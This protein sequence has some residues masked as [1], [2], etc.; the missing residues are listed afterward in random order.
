[1]G[2]IK[3]FMT[4]LLTIIMLL[5]LLLTIRHAGEKMRAG[6]DINSWCKTTP[7]HVHCMHMLGRNKPHVQHNRTQFRIMALEAAVDLAQHTQG[8]AS[9]LEKLC[10]SKRKKAVWKDCYKL[11]NNTILQLNQ[12][13]I[14]LKEHKISDFDA[15][16]WLSTALTNL[17]TCFSFSGE[18]NLTSFVSPIKTSNLTE[19]I[20]N[21]LAINQ[22]FLKQTQA[23]NKVEDFP[24]WVTKKDQKLLQTS[25]IYSRVNVTVSQA[26]GS[27]FRTIK[28]ALDYATSINRGD[29]RFIIYIKR[30]VYSENVE[31][32]N[33]LKNIMFLGDGL[34][35][36]IITG[37]RSMSGGFTTYSTATVGKNLNEHFNFVLWF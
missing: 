25:S 18:L 33:D 12:T 2:T 20:S 23:S 17:Q 3:L 8:C 30:G 37:N 29:G 35:Y 5:G 15:Q 32:G 14:G 11:V 1:M 7:H 21:N 36:T 16:T 22:F 4:F 13:L 9:N 6:G 28:S 34:R 26:K 24:I 19:T 27:K 31:I 10:H